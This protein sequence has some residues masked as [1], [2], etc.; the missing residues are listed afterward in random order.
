MLQDFV[1]WE[2]TFSLQQKLGEYF[3]SGM[4]SIFHKVYIRQEVLLYAST[5]PA[6]HT[7]DTAL[8]MDALSQFHW[9]QSIQAHIADF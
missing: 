4:D 7:V 9:M 6:R 2:L 5:V 8:V 3:N 1:Y